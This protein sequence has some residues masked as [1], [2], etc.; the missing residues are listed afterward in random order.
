MRLERLADQPCKQMFSVIIEQFGRGCRQSEPS[1]RVRLMGRVHRRAGTRSKDCFMSIDDFKDTVPAFLPEVFFVGRLE[2]WAVF[3][4]LVGG[5]QRRARINATGT[6]DSET[7]AVSLAE[8]YAF[9]DGIRTHCTGLSGSLRPE[10]TRVLKTVWT[11]KP[12]GIRRG[13][14][15]TGATRAIRRRRTGHQRN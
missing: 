2:G 6:L 13:V 9:D 15:F 1:A 8:T 14:R 12:M 5:L 4:S 7:G 11:V 3:E 10:S